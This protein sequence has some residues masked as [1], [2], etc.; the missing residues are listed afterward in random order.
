MKS[1][2]MHISIWISI[3]VAT[4]VGQGFWYAVIAEK[5]AEVASLQNQIDTKTET[6]GRVAAART[7]LAEIADDESAVQS[8]FVP[9]TRVVSFIDDLEARARAQAAT[10]KVLSVSIGD[11]AKKPTLVLSLTVNGTFDAVMRTVGAIEYAPYD[12]SILKL[13]LGKEEK[14]VWNANVELIVSSVPASTAT[15]TKETA[16]KVISLYYP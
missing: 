3:C 4:I 12:L 9:E 7:A 2:T 16:Q 5:S 11:D 14:S 10:M 8:Y 13:S 1:S 15:S 6:A